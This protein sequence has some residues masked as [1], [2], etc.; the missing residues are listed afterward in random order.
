MTSGALLPPRRPVEQGL[1]LTGQPQAHHSDPEG[2]LPKGRRQSPQTTGCN[3][4][5]KSILGRRV[6]QTP[7]GLNVFARFNVGARRPVHFVSPVPIRS[8]CLGE[9]P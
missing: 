7:R 8:H 6:V 4:I 3:F 5:R 1:V 9:Q 2:P